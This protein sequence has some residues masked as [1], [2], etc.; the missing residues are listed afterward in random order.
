MRDGGW[1]NS[2]SGSKSLKEEKKKFTTSGTV[3]LQSSL[4]WCY[5]FTIR[6]V[7]VCLLGRLGAFLWW[8]SGV[9]GPMG[10]QVEAFWGKL[11]SLW[12]V[13]L[14]CLKGAGQWSGDPACLWIASLAG[15]RGTVL[16]EIEWVCAGVRGVVQGRSW[17]PVQAW[18]YG[19]AE[20]MNVC[21]SRLGRA[22]GH[23]LAQ[24]SSSRPVQT[25]GA[26]PNRTLKYFE[27]FIQM[28]LSC[29]MCIYSNNLSHSAIVIFK[30]YPDY[31]YCWKVDITIIKINML[32]K[33][34]SINK[35]GSVL[36]WKL[37]YQIQ[38]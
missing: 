38:F 2:K 4:L 13:V 28:E 25:W 26:Q 29:E 11:A 10:L 34:D 36:L 30:L 7:C 9:W 15:F 27:P 32:I 19:P 8:V 3:E 17:R 23:G 24:R 20:I 16:A 1:S 14:M 37:L 5:S 18:G 12:S 21:G 22:W 33:N 6:S 35:C 31:F